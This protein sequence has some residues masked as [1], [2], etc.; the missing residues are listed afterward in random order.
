M[1]N[2]LLALVLS[3][4]V[5]TGPSSVGNVTAQTAHPQAMGL[6][7]LPAAPR[8]KSTVIGGAIRNVD[9]IRDQITLKV[10]GAGTMKILFDP[11][12]EVFRDG[13]KIPLLAMKPEEHAS[14][15]TVL[16]GT[17]VFARSIHILSE[18]PEGECNGQVVSYDPQT[19]EL[20]VK[21]ALTQ[22]A[23][24]LRVPDG[25]SI[26]RRVTE[27]QKTTM[28]AAGLTA[29]ALV[30]IRFSSAGSGRG[31]AREI[32]VLALPGQPVTF[33]G[34]VAYLDL[35]AHKLVVED[36]RNEESYSISYEPGEFPEDKKLHVGSPVTVEASFN[37]TGYEARTITP[38]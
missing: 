7:M 30:A 22:D 16:D 17:Q 19:R 24:T 13:K 5:T 14:V 6:E 28:D 26:Q 8:G 27:T 18:M 35:H 29:G 9:P 3:G 36:A 31:M 10:Y 20:R 37:G 12:T 11:R 2:Y 21:P 4:V 34:N 32:T 38:H 25:T 23:I 15:E 1:G 33:R